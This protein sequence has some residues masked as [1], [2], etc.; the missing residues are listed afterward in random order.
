[1]NADQKNPDIQIQD[2]NSV[3]PPPFTVV[4]PTR[5]VAAVAVRFLA[6]GRAVH[7]P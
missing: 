3:L 6:T 5:L 7:V 2:S 4:V 1:M